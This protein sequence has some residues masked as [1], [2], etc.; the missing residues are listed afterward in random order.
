MAE[1]DQTPESKT[2]DELLPLIQTAITMG[3]PQLATQAFAMGLITRPQLTACTHMMYTPD[4]Q[5]NTFL[6]NI[7]MQVVADPNALGS[8]RNILN[9]NAVYHHI[10]KKIGMSPFSIAPEDGLIGGVAVG[11]AIT[12]SVP[13]TL[14]MSLWRYINVQLR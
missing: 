3:V 2:F 6:Q 8:F 12:C 9:S 4:Q 14:Q 5:A 13:T 11:I 1:S 10:V 7:G